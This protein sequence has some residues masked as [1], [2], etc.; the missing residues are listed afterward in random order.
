MDPEGLKLT[1]F[2]KFSAVELLRKN[3]VRWAALN[4]WLS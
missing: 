4:P 1:V 2:D 3:E